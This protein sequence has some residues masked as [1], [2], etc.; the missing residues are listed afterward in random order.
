MSRTQDG[1]SYA[2]RVVDLPV[3]RPAPAPA[4]VLHG[5]VRALRAAVLGGM[6]LALAAGA[7]VLGGGT[8]P[9]VG[10][11]GVAAVLLALVAAV[12]TARRCRFGLLLGLLAV[13]QL[14][15]HELFGLAAAAQSCAV[16]SGAG[17]GMVHAGPMASVTTTCTSGAMPMET[18]TAGGLMVLAHVVATAV[19]AWLLA[20]GEAWLWRAVDRVAVAAALG[21]T[22]HT[23]SRRAE[24]PGHAAGPTAYVA[25]TWRPAGPR[26]P[27][28]G[29]R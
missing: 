17:A 16:R 1:R 9:G 11:L 29:V 28:F 10:V 24:L 14:A 15:L 4:R 26:G 25:A 21:A 13:Q 20:R 12:L 2:E 19:T 3:C 18:G 7:H 23:T 22:V 8:L 27:P 5:R 6:S